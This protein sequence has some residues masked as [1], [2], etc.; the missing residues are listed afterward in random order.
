MQ[1]NKDLLGHLKVNWTFLITPVCNTM[2]Y[3]LGY[4]FRGKHWENFSNFL[5]FPSKIKVA[6]SCTIS[7]SFFIIQCWINK[8]KIERIKKWR[9][10]YNA[11]DPEAFE[12]AEDLEDVPRARPEKV[13]EEK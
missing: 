13:K 9:G 12:D 3:Y 8:R 4:V 1:N 5:L 11:F 6:Y 10:K 2:A 7:W